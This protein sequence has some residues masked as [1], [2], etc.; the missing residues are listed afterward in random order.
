MTLVYTKTRLNS[1]GYK[2]NR[3]K[4]KRIQKDN[5][6]RDEREIYERTNGIN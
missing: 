5:G 3:S 2:I 1:R 6:K 4:N